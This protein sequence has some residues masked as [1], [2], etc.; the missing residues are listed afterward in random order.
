MSEIKVD[1]DDVI[2]MAFI[3]A[4]ED[5]FNDSIEDVELVEILASEFTALHHNTDWENHE[6]DWESEMY[7]LYLDRMNKKENGLKWR[8]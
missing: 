3:H 8:N 2:K 4:Q 6:S 5:R 7:E 1:I